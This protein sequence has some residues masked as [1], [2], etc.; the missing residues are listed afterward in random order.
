MTVCIIRNAEAETNAGIIRVVDALL[1]I[2]IMPLTLTRT[3]FSEINNKRIILKNFHHNKTIIKNYELQLKTD[4]GKGIRN[5][6]PLIAYQYLT[7]TW[8]IKNRKKYT[9]LHAFDLDAGIPALLA[10]KILRKK[11]V[12]HIADFYVDS[13][14]GIP[15]I[16]KNIIKKI[17]FKLISK[18][19]ATIIC[20]EERKEQIR[21]SKPNKLYVVHNTPVVQYE[22]EKLLKE[23]K[24]NEGKIKETYKLEIC[25]VGGLFETRFINQLIKIIKNN[26]EI[27]LSIAGLGPLENVVR[28]A[29]ESCE[30]I[31]YHG[32]VSYNRALDLYRECDL[33][34]AMYDPNIPNH[35][36]SAPNKVYEAM[37]LRK[38]IIVANGTGIDKIVQRE[39]IGFSIDYEEKDF[40]ETLNHIIHNPSQIEYLSDNSKIAYE[41][42]SWEIMK[43]RLQEIYKTLLNQE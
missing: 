43:G 27:S 32:R 7:L 21:G 11:F 29:A 9:E 4:M 42:Y 8:L 41:K 22:S 33:M 3:R 13:R 6:S 28:E 5:I 25:Y 20:T 1:D 10:S 12:Y 2:N 30:N 18:A 34:F 37:M 26:P 36:F 15:S 24:L 14:K 39:K 38:P 31:K 19:Q 35:K 40:I 17:E 23:G 16:I